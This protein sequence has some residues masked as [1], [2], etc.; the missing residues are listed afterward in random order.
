MFSPQLGKLKFHTSYFFMNTNHF[1]RVRAIFPRYVYVNLD[2]PSLHTHTYLYLVQ[3]KRISERNE[4][5]ENMPHY[6]YFLEEISNEY[7]I[8]STKYIL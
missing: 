1:W 6:I 5:R 3:K 4:L 7:F 2:L 8:L